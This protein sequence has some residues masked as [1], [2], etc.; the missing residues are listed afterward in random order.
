MGI[1]GE[2]TRLERGDDVVFG[3]HVTVEEG[4]QVAAVEIRGLGESTRQARKMAG[5]GRDG[6]RVGGSHSMDGTTQ[7]LEV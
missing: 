3:E 7:R 2:A 6:H 4:A 1:A 5:M